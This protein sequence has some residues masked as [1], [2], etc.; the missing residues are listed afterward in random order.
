VAFRAGDVRFVDQNADGIIDDRDRVVLG[1]PNPD[2]FGNFNVQLKWKRL[3]LGGIFSYSLGN[4][5]YNALRQQL[6]S[7]STL[8]NQ[9]VA[10]ENRWTADGQVTGIPRATYGDPMGNSRQSDRWVENASFLKLSQLSLTYDI[11]LHTSVL[12][13]L[14]VWASVNNLFTLTPYLGADPEFSLSS[15]V[16]TQGVDAG[17]VPNSRSFQLGV[18]INL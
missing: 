17:L 13:G 11:P 6:E 1:N 15:S 14:S 16:L 4:E 12:Q 18:K 8:H 7:G 5:A 10:M 3:T 2:I 9:T